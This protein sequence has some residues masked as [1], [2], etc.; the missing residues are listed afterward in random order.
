MIVSFR[1]YAAVAVSTGA[2]LLAGGCGKPKEP[3]VMQ[4]AVMQPAVTQSS[5]TQPAAQPG[6]QETSDVEVTQGVKDALLQDR[7]LKSFDIAV[8]TT[9]GDVRLTG[10]VENQ[11]QIDSALAIAR[12]VKGVH[13]LHDELTVKK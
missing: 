8:V 3:A 1:R 4:P 9:K 2:L 13:S 12:G 11:G 10:L 5:M 6:T 7:A